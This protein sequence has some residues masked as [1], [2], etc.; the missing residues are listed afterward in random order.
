MKYKTKEEQL[1]TVKQNAYVIADIKD[2]IENPYEQVK[3]VAVKQN[4]Y[5][6]F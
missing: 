6:I 4:E 1:E 2:S 5:A 3:L